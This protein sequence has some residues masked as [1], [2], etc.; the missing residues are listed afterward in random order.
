MTV[1]IA[2]RVTS[3]PLLR[4]SDVPPSHQGL[5]V[6]SVLNPA[7]AR[8]GGR[9]YLLLRIAERPVR[10]DPPP[11]AK[12]LELD[13]P[14]PT[15]VPLGSGH[16]ADDVVPIT[17]MNADD[18]QSRLDI[19]YLPK[20]LPGLDLSDPRGVTF[21]HPKTKRRTIFLQQ[22][23]HLR[24][25]SS[26]DGESF[27]V[28]PRPAIFPRGPLEEYGC[29]DARATC[30]NGT[31][32]VTYVSVSRIGITTSLATTKDFRTFKRHGV[33]LPPDQ[34]DVVL[35][36]ET[37]RGNYMALTRPMPSSFGHVLGIWLAI[38]DGEVLP[39]GHHVPLVLPRQGMWDEKQSGAG[40]VPLRTRHGWLEIYHGVDMENRYMLG[41]VL[42]DGDDPTR[43]LARSAEPILVP[44]LP[45]EREGLL[46]D[47]IFACG[48]VPLDDAGR[49]IRV[50]YGAA[51][52]CVA[53]ADFDVEEIVASLERM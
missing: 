26:E 48:H 1:D 23:S 29:E 53:A 21:T 36:P 46:N 28:D 37:V 40:T 32:Y 14:H 2:R 19:V 39:W 11:D 4:P 22:F 51:D 27:E 9:I 31:W 50:Y 15:L 3:E 24:L 33:I 10:G 41:G 18:P 6:A 47:I 49:R 30:I 52:S 35:F 13:G 38:P 25:A 44:E 17:L 34:K 5:E 8:C 16:R 12:T 7:A 20:D 42:L 45:Y 43:V